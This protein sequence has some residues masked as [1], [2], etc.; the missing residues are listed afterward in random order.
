MS[1]RGSSYLQVVSCPP[2]HLSLASPTG[3][4]ISPASP[5]S[6]HLSSHQSS[7]LSSILPS[8]SPIS[9]RPSLLASL[10]PSP[11]SVAGEA[12][13][14]LLRRGV[15][16]SLGAGQPRRLVPARL[17]GP[18]RHRR[19]RESESVV[20]QS[21]LNARTASRPPQAKRKGPLLPPVAVPPAPHTGHATSTH[22]PHAWAFSSS[23]IDMGRMRGLAHRC[24]VAGQRQLALVQLLRRGGQVDAAPRQV[25]RHLPRRHPLPA[26]HLAGDYAPLLSSPLLAS[27]LLA[28]P[29]LSSP[30]LSSPL[31]SSPLLSSP[32]LYLSRPEDDGVA[33]W[34]GNE[35]AGL[36]QEAEAN[37]PHH[38]FIPMVSPTFLC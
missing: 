29:L 21:A 12:A 14:G 8:L 10:L 28:S 5:L 32:L 34:F 24:L 22:G 36:T 1:R 9:P 16:H 35:A 25:G 33:L 11:L 23:H 37:C 27:P 20:V 31:L 17:R 30:R 15:V 6:S 18:G 3:A 13:A 38:V 19:T 26:R 7:P 4:S 2:C